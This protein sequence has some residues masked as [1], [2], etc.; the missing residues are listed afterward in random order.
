MQSWRPSLEREATGAPF[1]PRRACTGVVLAAAALPLQQRDEAGA[2]IVAS[3]RAKRREEDED[4]EEEERRAGKVFFQCPRQSKKMIVQQPDFFFFLSLCSGSTLARS[5]DRMPQATTTTL[6][7]PLRPHALA[8]RTD[9]AYVPDFV[10][11]REEEALLRH[12]KPPAGADAAGWRVL[13]GRRLKTLGGSV[14]R[15]A[16]T[17]APL[18]SWLLPLIERLRLTGAYAEEEGESGG[19]E[20]PDAQE[21]S[22]SKAPTSTSTSPAT[23]A[24]PASSS[25][26]PPPPNHALVNR[27]RSGEGILPHEDGPVYHPAAAIVSL[28]SWAVLRFY[29]KRGSDEDGGG[30]EEAKAETEEKEQEEGG[31]AKSK[32]S[33][34][35]TTRT[36][37]VF[38]VALAPRSLVVFAGEAYKELLHGIEAVAEEALDASVLNAADEGVTRSARERAEAAAGIG[39]SS[40]SPLLVIPRGEN[41]ERI[42]LTVRRVLRVRRNLLRLG[43]R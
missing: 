29:S 30:E 11:E 25:S 36:N 13:S 35:T 2:S 37:N 39:G 3:E 22:S 4:E 33:S 16:L 26:F 20:K 7:A 41:A 21:G 10:S 40:S 27:Y 32:R 43:P 19:G 15:G 9:V 14:D 42:S 8:P 38:S 1:L 24:S 5:I 18:P 23:S 6:P 17:A 28:G 31:G 12:L 34:G